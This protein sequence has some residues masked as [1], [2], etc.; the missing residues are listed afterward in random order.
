VPYYRLYDFI[1]RW[2]HWTTDRTEHF[3]LRDNTGR[4][5]GEGIDGYIFPSRCRARS[6]GIG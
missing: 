5:L 2:H 4:C 1:S 3:T 6:P